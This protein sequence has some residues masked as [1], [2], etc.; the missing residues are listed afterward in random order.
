MQYA[1]PPGYD[2]RVQW[3]PLRQCE[4]PGFEQQD[5]H[6]YPPLTEEEAEW[7][8]QRQLAEQEGSEEDDRLGTLALFALHAC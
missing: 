8:W 6:G 3:S 4:D 5:N 2:D 1:G 7:E